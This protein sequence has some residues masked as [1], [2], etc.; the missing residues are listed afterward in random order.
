MRAGLGWC[1]SLLAGPAS[2]KVHR[3]VG[4]AI[5]T[6]HRYRACIGSVYAWVYLP[7]AI[8]AGE[9]LYDEDHHVPHTIV[10]DSPISPRRGKVGHPYGWQY[11]SLPC[12]RFRCTFARLPVARCMPMFPVLFGAYHATLCLNQFYPSSAH[13]TLNLWLTSLTVETVDKVLLA[14]VQVCPTG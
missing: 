5:C 12:V 14:T 2:C 10:A 7:L 11:I 3:P 13:Y 4:G 8:V 1:S 6:Q 9:A